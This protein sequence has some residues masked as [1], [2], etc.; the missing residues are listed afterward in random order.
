MNKSKTISPFTLS[1]I[2]NKKHKKCSSDINDNSTNIINLLENVHDNFVL[3]EEEINSLKNEFNKY[4]RDY[5][6]LVSELN[7]WKKIFDK[8]IYEFLKNIQ[9]FMCNELFKFIRNFSYD[10][11]N[12]NDCVK[13][14]KIFNETFGNKN[15]PFMNERDFSLSKS[16]LNELI[17]SNNNPNDTNKFIQCSFKVLNYI[18][19]LNK[20]CQNSFEKNEKQN[21]IINKDS[22]SINYINNDNKPVYNEKKIIEKYIDFKESNSQNRKKN[23]LSL[24]INS[25]SNITSR[26]INNLTNL[27]KNGDINIESLKTSQTSYNLLKTSKRHNQSSIYLKKSTTPIVDKSFY[28]NYQIANMKT[29]TDSVNLILNNSQTIEENKYLNKNISMKNCTQLNDNSLKYLELSSLR[30]INNINSN[31]KVNSSEKIIFVFIIIL[32]I[33]KNLN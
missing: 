24:Q 22:L 33:I 17:T 4:S 7:F 25:Q 15:R 16:I 32:V 20:N 10:K 28:K 18:I 26:N 30:K 27:E 21:K 14:K 2:F 31:T 8:K 3:N 9:D 6:L 29:N 12:F 19:D 23:N 5:S 1:P 13:F 11:A